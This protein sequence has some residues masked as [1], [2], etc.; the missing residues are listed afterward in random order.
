MDEWVDGWVDGWMSGWIDE[1]MDGGVDGWM[2]EW[3]GRKI[4]WYL[5]RQID[6]KMNKSGQS[7]GCTADSATPSLQPPAA[8]AQMG[9]FAWSGSQS[10][11]IS[12]K[13]IAGSTLCQ[14]DLRVE[15]LVNG[16]QVRTYIK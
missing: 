10:V 6:K 7:R 15:F 1:W 14:G 9:S 2:N 8:D 3:T 4:F 5:Y 12:G 16:L 13:G 11:L